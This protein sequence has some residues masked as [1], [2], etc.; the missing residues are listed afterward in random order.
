LT[1]EQVAKII[2]WQ[3]VKNNGSCLSHRH[4]VTRMMFGGKK[5]KGASLQSAGRVHLQMETQHPGE[6][7]EPGRW[8][9]EAALWCNWRHTGTAEVGEARSCEVL[10]LGA[11]KLVNFM[12]SR[13]GAIGQMSWAFARS[14]QMMLSLSLGKD[15]PRFDRPTDLRMPFSTDEVIATMPPEAK[16]F[17][18]HVALRELKTTLRSVRG[19]AH[20]LMTSM[21]EGWPDIERIRDEVDKGSSTVVLSRGSRLGVRRIETLVRL[22]LR[23]DDSR[24]L[25]VVRQPD[26]T[27]GPEA[28]LPDLRQEEGEYP[29]ECYTRLI[30]NHFGSMAPGIV[31]EYI[32]REDQETFSEEL[33]IYTRVV[34]VVYNARWEPAP[35]VV[36]KVL[37]RRGSLTDS[38][39][40][41]AP[42]GA[43]DNP[44]DPLQT[45]EVFKLPGGLMVA[46][47]TSE[48][49]ERCS[50]EDGSKALTQWLSRLTFPRRGGRMPTP[51]QSRRISKNSSTTDLGRLD[52]WKSEGS[53]N[54]GAVGSRGVEEYSV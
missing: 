38:M 5:N 31:M 18:G 54:A 32:E 20:G 1:D 52:V 35:E 50:E 11:D 19:M 9:S 27:E 6:L 29:D 30:A 47:F 17:V 46:W 53:S 22:Q 42:L 33:G 21:T 13:P 41:M 10:C 51:R 25:V 37:S 49:L 39:E 34:K 36:E 7:V 4:D 24:V 45:D 2:A 48:E 44:W 15:I 28:K 40:P 16:A 26:A 3:H 23:R 14:F 8:L 43:D 12:K